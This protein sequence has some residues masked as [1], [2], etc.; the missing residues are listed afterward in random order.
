MGKI[1]DPGQIRRPGC[2]HNRQGPPTYFDGEFVYGEKGDYHYPRAPR[3]DIGIESEPACGS[4]RGKLDSLFN[5][6]NFASETD[7]IHAYGFFMMSPFAGASEYRPPYFITGESGSGKST[8]L[9]ALVAISDALLARGDST[10]EPGIRHNVRGTRPLAINEFEQE[11]RA[12]ADSA[13][14]IQALIRGTTDRDGGVSLLAGGPSENRA[15]AM[16]F[17]AMVL[18]AAID[19]STST[20]ADHNRFLAINLKKFKDIDADAYQAWL[21]ALTAFLSPETCRRIR[22]FAWRNL[23]KI[24]ELEKEYAGRIQQLSNLDL[25]SSRFHAQALACYCVFRGIEDSPPFHLY[26]G[27]GVKRSQSEE[28]LQKLMDGRVKCEETDET[29]PL[30]EILDTKILE[31]HPSRETWMRAI[32]RYGLRVFHVKGEAS[33]SL[34]IASNHREVVKLLKDSWGDHVSPDY[35]AI[36]RRHPDAKAGSASHRIGGSPRRCVEIARI[37]EKKPEHQEK[38]VASRLN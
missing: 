26:Q 3:R 20:I 5:W 17:S 27:Y 18:V 10:T 21:K 34:C 23:L 19:P 6:V 38:V 7:R 28:M 35:A 9:N 13:R 24:W 12:R 22:S 31:D 25:R 4:I 33:Y 2:W 32:Q 16:T 14:R 8:V 11:T 36:L 37:A 29:L 30:A 15:Q 1:Y